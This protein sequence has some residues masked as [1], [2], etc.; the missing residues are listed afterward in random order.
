MLRKNI[1][2]NNDYNSILQYYIRRLN[3]IKCYTYFF[4]LLL[5]N[6]HLTINNG[7]CLFYNQLRTLIQ[8]FQLEINLL[9]N[10]N[11]YFIIAFTSAFKRWQIK[12]AIKDNSGF[13]LSSLSINL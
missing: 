12:G 5:R 6:N 9:R 10:Y 2:D 7:Y 8:I 3:C 1:S 13:E 11:I 4:S